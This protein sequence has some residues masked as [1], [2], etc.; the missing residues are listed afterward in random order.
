VECEFRERKGKG[1]RL[2]SESI[3]A[4]YID[5]SSHNTPE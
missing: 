5:F 4:I 2:I 1:N 3:E